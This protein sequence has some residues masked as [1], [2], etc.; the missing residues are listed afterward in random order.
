MS[1]REEFPDYDDKLVIPEGF[2]DY[3]WHND[4]CPHVSKRYFDT[5][6]VEAKVNIWQDYKNP[7]LRDY[8]NGKR[9]LFQIIVNGVNIMLHET[10]DWS[11]IE[12]LVAMC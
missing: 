5:P 10:D 4:C 2:E 8:D 1:Y 11:E 7:A 6:E 9:F 12:K 3:S